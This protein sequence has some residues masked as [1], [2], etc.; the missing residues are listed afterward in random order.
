[1]K[2][3]A[4]LSFSKLIGQVSSYCSDVKKLTVYEIL[5]ISSHNS[6]GCSALT[7]RGKNPKDLR[8]DKT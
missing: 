6:I 5:A 8:R 4:N 7:N 2:H 3:A 1:M